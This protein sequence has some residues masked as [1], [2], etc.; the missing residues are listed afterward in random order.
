MKASL[1]NIIAVRIKHQNHIGCIN[2]YKLLD[3]IEYMELDYMDIYGTTTV[4]LTN[5][6]MMVNM[7]NSNAILVS[8]LR[9]ISEFATL[10]SQEFVDDVFLFT[11]F[12]S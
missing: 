10:C 12:L 8:A 7:F 6:L 5:R 1:F 4:P 3:Y 9:G 11:S 2:I